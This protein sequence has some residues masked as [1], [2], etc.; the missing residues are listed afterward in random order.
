MSIVRKTN[1]FTLIELLIVISILGVLST[2]VLVAVNPAKRSGQAR[3]AQRK[4][5]LNQVSK[6]L[7]TYYIDHSQYPS[8]VG[9]P[10]NEWYGY[11]EAYGSK[12]T[13]GANGWVPDLAPDYIKTLPLDPKRNENR[14]SQMKNEGANTT[15]A[16]TF[17]YIYKSDGQDYKIAA[18]CGAESEP[19]NAGDK[20]YKGH[21]GWSCGNWHYAIWTKGAQLW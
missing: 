20:F 21:D 8:T 2:V 15:L 16:Y 10:F 5:A 11:C 12:D 9:D 6:A 4:M 19:A 13:S 7:E 3:D 17:C 18:H 14:N 1:G